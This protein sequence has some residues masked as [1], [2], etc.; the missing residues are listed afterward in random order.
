MTL[1]ELIVKRGVDAVSALPDGIKRNKE[2]V[3]ET[4]EN[5]IRKLII[6]EL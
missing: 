2:A 1:I 4:I 6:D 3:A 5:N